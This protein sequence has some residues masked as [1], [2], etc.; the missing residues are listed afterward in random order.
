MSKEQ[1]DKAKNKKERKKRIEPKIPFWKSRSKHGR[2][3]LFESSELLWEAA[4]EY[5][6]WCEENPLWEEKLFHYQ[7][8]V[9]TH[10]A[11]KLRVYTMIGLCLYVKCSE[12]YF[13]AFK[14]RYKDTD[15]EKDFMMVINDIEQSIK[16][17]QIAGASADL[18]NHNII[19]RLLG[20]ADV[21]EVKQTIV[22]FRNV[23]KQYPKGLTEETNKE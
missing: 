16:E 23:S 5:F 1:K 20:L 11:A 22:E 18:L 9:T 3:K 6:I 14:N 13:R 8:K 15:K 17:Q 10:R 19:S 2:D 7:G 4:V 21:T 12:N